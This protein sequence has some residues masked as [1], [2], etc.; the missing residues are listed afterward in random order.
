MAT[1]PK[2]VVQAGPWGLSALHVYLSFEG[3]GELFC[4]I[5]GRAGTAG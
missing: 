2:D 5:L 3:P 1:G 4:Y